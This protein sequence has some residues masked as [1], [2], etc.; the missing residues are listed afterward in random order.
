MKTRF[1][2]KYFVSYCRFSFT[3]KSVPYNA[4]PH[5]GDGPHYIKATIDNVKYL[6]YSGHRKTTVNQRQN[7]FER[8]SIHKY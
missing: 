1:S 8:P 7:D 6:K 5:A 3:Y 2:L 4:K